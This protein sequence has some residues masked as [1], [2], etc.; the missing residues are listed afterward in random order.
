MK[1]RCWSLFRKILSLLVSLALVGQLSCAPTRPPNNIQETPKLNCQKIVIVA[2]LVTPQLTVEGIPHSRPEG[3]KSLAGK[4]FKGCSEALISTASGGSG[5]SDGAIIFVLVVATWLGICGVASLVA[6]ASGAALAP[7]A[8]TMVETE[9]N[10]NSPLAVQRLQEHFR[11]KMV[12]T[13][14]SQGIEVVELV[15]PE[16]PPEPGLYD[17]EAYRKRGVDS[18]LEVAISKLAVSGEGTSLKKTP[19]QLTLSAQSRALKVADGSELDLGEYH[20]H[21]S[22]HTVDEW[23]ANDH[24]QL[25]TEL[26]TGIGYLTE[27]IF[28][29][30]INPATLSDESL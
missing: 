2:R 5:G 21:G 6:S 30:V 15:P 14:I 13:A 4:T 22:R 9:E 17:L 26:E 16:A 23:L 25:S 29:N 10:L 27:L 12:E 11:A 1:Q 28:Y 20:F 3:A 7:S 18:V 19:V 24:A 8:A